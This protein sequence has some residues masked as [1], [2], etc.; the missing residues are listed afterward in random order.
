M[1]EF[2]FRLRPRRLR[3]CRS[4]N[5]FGIMD[6]SSVVNFEFSCPAQLKQYNF[7]MNDMEYYSSRT[8]NIET[9]IAL[10][11]ICKLGKLQKVHLTY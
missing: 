10:F 3:R 6:V 9:H 7:N 11:F 2:V 4:I 8:F 5:R 1:D